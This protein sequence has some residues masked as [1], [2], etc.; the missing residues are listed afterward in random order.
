MPEPVIEPSPRRCSECHELRERDA[1]QDEGYR[2]KYCDSMQP[3]ISRYADRADEKKERLND[4]LNRLVR[5]TLSRAPELPGVTEI[6]QQMFHL[7]GG[8]NGL[9]AAWFADIHFAKPGSKTRLEQYTRIVQLLQAAVA[10]QQSQF[11]I[12]SASEEELEQA[13]RDYVLRIVDDS[14]E[15]E[16]HVDSA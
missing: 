15:A 7:F 14:K 2:C 10:E 6:C 5:A 11:D 13:V 8:L 3:E 4:G 9:C 1:F 16:A 12:E